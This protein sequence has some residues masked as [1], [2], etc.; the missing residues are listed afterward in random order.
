MTKTC[1]VRNC[2]NRNL[3]RRTPDV[4]RPVKVVNDPSNRLCNCVTAFHL[5]LTSFSISLKF[6]IPI[7]NIL[8]L[9][10]A[11]GVFIVCLFFKSSINFFWRVEAKPTLPNSIQIRAVRGCNCNCMTRYASRSRAPLS[12][13]QLRVVC[14]MA[15]FCFE[16]FEPFPLP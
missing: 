12:I 4:F 3:S 15:C 6:F 11:P 16:I 14:W 8:K 5:E 2:A 13:C 7:I 10:T 9:H 1:R